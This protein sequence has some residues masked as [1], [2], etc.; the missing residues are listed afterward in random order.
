[1][2]RCALLPNCRRRL[3]Q[4]PDARPL[5]AALSVHRPR[6]PAGA[7]HATANAVSVAA[8]RLS[9]AFG[10]GGPSVAV[11]T[12]CSA[13][14][15][16]LHLAARAIRSGE[17]TAALVAGVHVQATPTSSHYVHQAAMLSAA[18]RCQVLDAA[19][20]GYVRGEACIA[21][22]LAPLSAVA[23]G[24]PL[25]LILGAAVNQDGRSSSL[26]APNG[27]AQQA[28]IRAALAA[29]GGLSPADVAALSMHGT[30]TPLGDPIEV[31]AASSAL[32]GP[33]RAG[34]SP[35]TL[36]A[37]KSHAGHAEPAAG[38]VAL[39]HVALAAASAAA[40]PILHL[41]SL[42]PHVA[43]V[44]D[45]AGGVTIARQ[46]APLPSLATGGGGLRYGISSFAFMGTNAH[47]LAQAA[48]AASA[49]PAPAPM[50][51]RARQHWVAPPAHLLVRRGGL[52]SGG[53]GAPAL[54][55]EA[56]LSAPQL[57]YV[58]HH[59]VAGVPLFPGAGFLEMCAAAAA[60]AVDRGG[61][62]GWDGALARGALLGASM[63]APLRLPAAGDGGG[64]PT[65]QCM[66][67][68][69]TGALAIRSYPPDGKRL[70]G[71]TTHLVGRLALVSAQR[72]A[73]AALPGRARGC[74]A[75]R[76]AAA[77]SSVACAS[78][79]GRLCL[80]RAAGRP[81]QRR[82]AAG[83]GRPRLLAAAGSGIL[84]RRRP[85]CALRP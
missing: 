43:G 21:L 34:A 26:T 54:V 9:F 18:G 81:A 64:M 56:D 61:G 60:A 75:A 39:L 20:D 8:G 52:S 85:L 15:V 78:T 67:D 65:L 35:L 79:R 51:W 44:L 17:A 38:I 13:S 31:N 59:V 53:G 80:C 30:G 2:T 49:A 32:C 50:A 76:R 22:V 19:A 42:N 10:L 5:T 7:F 83:P 68:A 40:A 58:W 14:L 71:A 47:V 70:A 57:A 73:A 48:P 29:A 16:A 84:A 82:R 24:V 25:A 66:L 23:G 1:M 3:L 77:A 46:A 63:P 72:A 11:D 33:L 4:P 12:A 28:A 37:S 45:G 41:R 6:A 62:G 55:L 74:G 69:R 27:P 36:A